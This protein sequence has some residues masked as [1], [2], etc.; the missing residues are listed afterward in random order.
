M[1]YRFWS[2]TF[3]A[4]IL[5]W[6]G[7]DCWPRFTANSLHRQISHG[8]KVQTYQC[9]Y[10]L[11][12]IVF[13]LEYFND[14]TYGKH[15]TVTSDHKPSLTIYNEDLTSILSKLTRMLPHIHKYSITSV[16]QNDKITVKDD[17]NK[18]KSLILTEIQWEVN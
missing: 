7:N 8:I 3:V 4:N 9:R 10:E 6:N 2:I 14:C 5:Q 17:V 16:L 11:L 15:I 13:I 18:D 1:W 12:A